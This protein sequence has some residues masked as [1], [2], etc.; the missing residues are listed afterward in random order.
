M[1]DMT[2]ID[3]GHYIESIKT[4]MD[5]WRRYIE[6]I[7]SRATDAVMKVVGVPAADDDA[8]QERLAVA[9]RDARHEYLDLIGDAKLDD[10]HVIEQIAKIASNDLRSQK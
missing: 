1:S 8:Q 3:W 9:V 6:S 4:E 5:D 10:E 2:E 7:E